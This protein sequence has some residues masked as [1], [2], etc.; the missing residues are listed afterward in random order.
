MSSAVSV[1]LPILAASHR[2]PPTPR[3][4]WARTSRCTTPESSCPEYRSACYKWLFARKGADK[5]TEGC[6]QDISLIAINDQC[7]ERGWPRCHNIV[8]QYQL[9]RLETPL[10]AFGKCGFNGGCRLGNGSMS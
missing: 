7:G 5:V 9:R 8:L 4:P 3:C 1:E 6:Q 10:L 2:S